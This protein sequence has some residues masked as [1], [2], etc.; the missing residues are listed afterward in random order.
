MLAECM[1]EKDG[2][3]VVVLTFDDYSHQDTAFRERL[4]SQGDIY[5][6]RRRFSYLKVRD[7]GR[8]RESMTGLEFVV[9]PAHSTISLDNT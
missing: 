2:T 3:V 5:I 6:L 8:S 4:T 9:K 7:E 1:I